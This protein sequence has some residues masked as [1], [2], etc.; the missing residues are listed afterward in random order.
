MP[1]WLYGIKLPFPGLLYGG[2]EGPFDGSG[3]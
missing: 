1:F 3:V 2:G